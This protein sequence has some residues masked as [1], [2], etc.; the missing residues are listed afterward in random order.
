[1]FGSLI[2]VV[3][4]SL[5]L[6]IARAHVVG[7]PRAY[8]RLPQIKNMGTLKIGPGFQVRGQRFRVGIA[9]GPNGT[10]NIGENVFLNQGVSIAAMTTITIGSHAKIADLVTIQ[11][12]H[13]HRVSPEESVAAAPITIGRNAWLGR[14][15]IINPGVTI[16][17]NAVVAAGSI[18][19]RDVQP[20]TVVAGAPAKL[21]RVFSAPEGWVRE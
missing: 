2:Q 7:A 20:N 21:V 1:M 19:T 3:R 12:T 10:L 18:V 14:L 9:V 5:V 17:E 11:D 8:G 4:A 15:S 6:R 13:Y 16:G